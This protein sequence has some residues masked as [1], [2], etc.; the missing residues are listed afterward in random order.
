M[1]KNVGYQETWN[2]I[3]TA[4]RIAIVSHIG[5]DGDTTGSGLA[6]AE[7]LRQR[8]RRCTFLWMMSFPRPIDS[9]PVRMGTIRWRK[10]R[11]F[12][13]ILLLWLM[14]APRTGWGPMKRPCHLP[15]STSITIFLIRITPTTCSLT[16][17]QR[18]PVRSF[19]G[20]LRKITFPSIKTWPSA[21]IRQLSR[22]AAS[23]SMEIRR[24][25]A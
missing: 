13:R 12:P 7:A 6:L 21:F 4:S 20:S 25:R 22:T 8:E 24:R 10:G 19:I 18:Q 5:P 3:M 23:L 16:Q 11:P 2:L 1:S 17:R 14:L 9:C 15:S